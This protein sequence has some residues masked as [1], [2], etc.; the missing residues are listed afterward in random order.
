MKIIEF[1]KKIKNDYS[2]DCIVRQNGTLLLKPQT[3]PKCKFM[4]YKSLKNEYIEDYVLPYFE[5]VNFP[6]DYLK[7]LKCYN[8]ADLFFVKLNCGKYSF[9]HPML[10]ILGLPLTKPFERDLDME[11]PSD[12]RVENLARNKSIP[13]EWI[14]CAIWTEIK[15]IGKGE[16][17][18][19]FIDSLTNKVYGCT[20]NQCEILYTW[21]NLDDCLCYIIDSFKGL[22]DEYSI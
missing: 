9:A 15:N 6:Q 21:D 1:L 7:L 19:I 4:I 5:N 2:E 14:K 12:V 10:V 22:E 17:T 11:E 18:D 16:P 20:K 13:N 3:V 8:G